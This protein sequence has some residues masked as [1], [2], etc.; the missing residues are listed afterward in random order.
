M[1]LRTLIDPA[2]QKTWLDIKCDEI[3]AD[4]DII[5]KYGKDYKWEDGTKRICAD[6]VNGVDYNSNLKHRFFISGAEK[7]GVTSTD[8]E[9]RE[10]L[11][12][13]PTNF[14]Q[15]S[16]QVFSNAGGALDLSE[17][18]HMSS[19]SSSGDHQLTLA[20]SIVGHR[21]KLV[22][23]LHSGTDDFV[24]TPTNLLQF[25]TISFKAQGQFLELEFVAGNWAIINIGFTLPAIADPIL[26]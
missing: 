20:D 26:A 10:R 9:L 5:L 25:S 14:V 24:L 1:S 6:N 21:I 16:V 7:L 3:D 13:F 18:I 11:S 12:I 23:L 4:S 17:S 15:H 19:S 2:L 8:I 22:C